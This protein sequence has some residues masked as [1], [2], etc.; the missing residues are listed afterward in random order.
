M[1]C[2]DTT[3]QKYGGCLYTIPCFHPWPYFYRLVTAV[4]HPNVNL[5]SFSIGVI[6]LDIVIDSP[7]YV[8]SQDIL[9]QFCSYVTVRLTL[10][11]THA[12]AFVAIKPENNIGNL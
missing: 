2:W 1:L 7:F 9:R 6:L 5:A 8:F 12:V 11:V 3:I 4:H 10:R